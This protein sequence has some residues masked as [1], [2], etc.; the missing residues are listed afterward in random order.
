M[1]L[2]VYRERLAS[3]PRSVSLWRDVFAEFVATF[4]LVSVQSALP[5]TWGE[6]G[7]GGP[8]QTALGMGF[9]VC[10]MAWTFGDFSGGH[11]NPAVTFSM[12]LSAK[13]TVVRALVYVIAQCAG[14][15]AGTGFVYLMTPASRR[16]GLS[17]TMVNAEL[18]PWQGM[19]VEAWITAIL[20]L[21]IYGSTNDNRKDTLFMPTIPIGFAITLGILTG[22]KYT[23]GSMNPARSF[24]PALILNLWTHHWVYWTG[25]LLGGAIAT[26]VYVWFVDRIGRNHDLLTQT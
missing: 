9:I 3:E 18:E 8:V 2:S 6:A 25:P 1:K 11:M 15:A 23:G 4:M 5:L 26:L 7:I 17:A 24:G 14:G 21:T 10:T 13:I 20:V 12:A 19:L 22:W 16:E